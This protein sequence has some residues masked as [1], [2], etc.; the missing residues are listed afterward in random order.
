MHPTLGA[1]SSGPDWSYHNNQT[2]L[3]L[4]I[5]CHDRSEKE[6]CQ[7]IVLNKTSIRAAKLIFV[8]V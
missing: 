5:H 3:L 6:V 2:K 1:T 4:I 7:V 8:E